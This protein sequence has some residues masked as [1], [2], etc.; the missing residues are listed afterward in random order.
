MILVKLVSQK[1]NIVMANATINL[2]ILDLKME[3]K[4]REKKRLILKYYLFEFCTSCIG[5]V[6]NRET[7]KLCPIANV[8]RMRMYEVIGENRL[9]LSC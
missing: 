4:W 7:G 6:F 2:L 3:K 9:R 5:S 1:E 8:L